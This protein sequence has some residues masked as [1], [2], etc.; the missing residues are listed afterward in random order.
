[1]GCEAVLGRPLHE[2][3]VTD[4]TILGGQLMRASEA[5]WEHLGSGE[6]PSNRLAQVMDV[7]DVADV[8]S[9]AAHGYQLLGAREGEQTIHEGNSLDGAVILDGGRTNRTRERFFVSLPR[10]G[11]LVGIARIELGAEPATLHI[12]VGGVERP[13]IDVEPGPWTEVVF[14]LPEADDTRGSRVEL[15]MT[16]SAPFTSFHYWFGRR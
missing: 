9:E 7:L 6:A 3:V 11:Q 2:A 8:E 5:R 14:D 13:P 4:A 15:E 10:G 12:R 1:M 16:A